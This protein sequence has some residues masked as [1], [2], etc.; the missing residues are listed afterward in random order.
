MQDGIVEYP[1]DSTRGHLNDKGL[2]EAGRTYLGGMMSRGMLVDLAHM[3]DRS[4]IDALAAAVNGPG[5]IYPVMMSHAGYRELAMQADYSDKR[6]ALVSGV[7]VDDP[8]CILDP[9]RRCPEALAAAERRIRA[10]LGAHPRPG[11]M[12]RGLLPKEFDVTTV[13]ADRIKEFGGVI[14]PFTGQDPVAPFAGL[15]FADDCA[16]SSKGFAAALL[17]AA[18]HQGAFGVGL[19]TDFGFHATVAPRFGP[20]AC[21]AYTKVSTSPAEQLVEVLLNRDQYRFSAQHRG[22][23]YAGVSNPAVPDFADNEPLLPYEMGR[24]AHDFNVHGLAHYG[25]LPDMLQDVKNL[26]VD[27]TP[28]FSSAE[29]YLRMWE[30]AW[31]AA[32]CDRDGHCNPPPRLADENACGEGCPDAWNAGAPLQSLG[33]RLERCSRSRS[34]SIEGGTPMY[35]PAKVTDD[36]HYTVYQVGAG[37]IRWRCE[38]S[39]EASISCEGQSSGVVADRRC[40]PAGTRY[41]KVRRGEERAVFF[42]CLAAPYEPARLRHLPGGKGK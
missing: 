8:S 37:P 1:N 33:R 23:R 24:R 41:V 35:G 42:E 32:G 3:S 34:V 10:V 5:G 12:N 14:G 40:C 16:M 6:S 28:L 15:P 18:R 11:T 39:L 2:T 38:D 9:E 25:L 20:G 4:S 36:E 26:G 29:G 22:V 21:A 17:F 19:A 27:L 13:Q 30:K 7:K 31:K